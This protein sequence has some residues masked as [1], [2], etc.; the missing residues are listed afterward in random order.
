MFTFQNGSGGDE[1]SLGDFIHSPFQVVDDDD[2][3]DN[4]RDGDVLGVLMK[5]HKQVNGMSSYD[6]GS[7]AIAARVA[8]ESK[9]NSQISYCNQFITETLTSKSFSDSVR[10][11]FVSSSAETET[12]P[13]NNKIEYNSSSVQVKGDGQQVANSTTYTAIN[14]GTNNTASVEAS[15]ETHFSIPMNNKAIY[16]LNDNIHNS[17]NSNHMNNMNRF[18]E[19]IETPS[20]TAN[21]LWNSFHTSGSAPEIFKQG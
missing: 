1:D 17:N 2:G 8:A 7:F 21:D 14:R 6:S 9:Q 4:S 20:I 13:R 15:A 16:D 3:D 10:S 12:S 19:R 11:M 18:E 5:T